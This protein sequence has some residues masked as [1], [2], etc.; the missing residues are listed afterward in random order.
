MNHIPDRLWAFRSSTYKEYLGVNN[1]NSL[2]MQFSKKPKE[3]QDR[4]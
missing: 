4:G 3:I 1:G 2:G